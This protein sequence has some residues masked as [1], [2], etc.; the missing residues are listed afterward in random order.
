MDQLAGQL[1]QISARLDEGDM[2]KARQAQEKAAEI[3]SM[4]LYPGDPDAAPSTAWQTD[5]HA[6]MRQVVR[7]EPVPRIP[8]APAVE[9]EAGINDREAAD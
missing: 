9:A 5:L 1:R 4:Q 6:R 8:H 3:T 2:R 7:H